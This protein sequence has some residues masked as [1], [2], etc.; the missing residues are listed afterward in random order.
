[1]HVCQIQL[2]QVWEEKKPLPSTENSLDNYMD[3]PT[4]SNTALLKSWG[5]VM[6]EI[7][8]NIMTSRTVITQGDI[9]WPHIKYYYIIF[10]IIVHG[11][12]DLQHVVLSLDYCNL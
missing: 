7:G 5:K 2:I 11:C 6:V 1:M 3:H 9:Y 12:T 4:R 8:Q 10:K